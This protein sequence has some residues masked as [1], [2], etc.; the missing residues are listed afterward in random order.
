[1]LHNIIVN[2]IV[3]GK[4]IPIVHIIIVEEDKN[5]IYLF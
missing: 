5:V 3:R 1:M 4:K 2:I